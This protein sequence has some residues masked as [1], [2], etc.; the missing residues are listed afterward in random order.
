MAKPAGPG[1]PAKLTRAEKKAARA[2]KRA[3]RRET[4]RNVWQAFTLTRRNDNRLIPYM[5]ISGVL[6]AAVVYFVVSLFA[7]RYLPI[8]VAVLA[9]GVVAL[10]V[11]SRRAQTSM[12]TQAEG[13]PG[14]AAWLLQ[15]NLRG[16][17]RVAAGV[18]GTSQLDA[19]HRLVGRPGVVLVGEGAPHRVRGLV[20]QEKKRVARVA[21]DTPIYDVIVGTDEGEVPLRK[22]NNY[23]FKLPRNLDKGQ[24][25][26]LDKRLQA[27]GGGKPP[28]PGGPMPTGAKVRNVQRTV[29][30]RT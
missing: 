26:A 8:P 12:Y 13:T 24:V 17:W 10:F 18:A 7:G 14:A 11:F 21:G 4:W 16:D 9:G 27:L 23:L 19:V 30:R 29:R 25:S 5:I 20:A 6:T 1:K 2:T 15:N 22:L 3:S 28:L